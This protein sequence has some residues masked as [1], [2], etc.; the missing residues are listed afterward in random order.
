MQFLSFAIFS[1]IVS[2]V[3]INSVTV[4]KWFSSQDLYMVPVLKPVFIP[5]N[6]YKY[7]LEC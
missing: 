5:V 6:S 4:C 3:S 1:V 7:T 2:S